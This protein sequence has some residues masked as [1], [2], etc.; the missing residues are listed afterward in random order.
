MQRRDNGA[1]VDT[2]EGGVMNT[3]WTVVTLAFVV[4]VVGTAWVFLI[5]PFV[6]PGRTAR[7]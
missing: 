3:L 2:S 1:E 5:A 4:A 6:V 7:R